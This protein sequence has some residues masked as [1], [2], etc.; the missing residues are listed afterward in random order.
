LIR[1]LPKLDMH[2]NNSA[3]NYSAG[4]S[5]GVHVSLGLLIISYTGRGY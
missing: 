1:S 2:P 4:Q 5:P 3:K